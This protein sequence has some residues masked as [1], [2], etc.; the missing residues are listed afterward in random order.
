MFATLVVVVV[1]IVVVVLMVVVLISVVVVVVLIV[2]FV[3]T[4]AHILVADTAAPLVLYRIF[5]TSAA[6]TLNPFS[7]PT[8]GF[9]RV[10]FFLET[11]PSLICQTMTFLRHAHYLS[12]LCLL[13]R[14]SATHT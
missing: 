12:R 5:R 3:I 4:E 9:P 6:F 10:F 8:L 7:T 1:L 2:V 11:S 13:A 14:S